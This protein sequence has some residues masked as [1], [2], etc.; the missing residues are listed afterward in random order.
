MEGAGELGSSL[1]KVNLVCTL[2]AG[3]RVVPRRQPI[4]PIRPDLLA[5]FDVA[6]PRKYMTGDETGRATRRRRDLRGGDALT[7]YGAVL[8]NGSPL[9]SRR[10]D[11]CQRS[12]VPGSMNLRTARPRRAGGPASAAGFLITGHPGLRV[13]TGIGRASPAAQAAPNIARFVN[14]ID[15]ISVRS[16]SRSWCSARPRAEEAAMRVLATGLVA[17]SYAVHSVG[18]PLAPGRADVPWPCNPVKYISHF[19]ENREIWSFGSGYGGNALLGKK[20]YA[21]AARRR[22]AHDPRR[23]RNDP[24]TSASSRG[25]PRRSRTRP[26]TEQLRTSQAGT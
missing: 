1:M 23:H 20:C 8:Q 3:G 12:A 19:P 13:A 17:G 26:D 22:N 14:C 16:L 4:L 7:G 10:L 18:A 21:L 6:E 25:E 15:N 2:D 5:L 11:A 9:I 24:R